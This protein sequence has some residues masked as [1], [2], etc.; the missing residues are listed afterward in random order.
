VAGKV[1]RRLQNVGKPAVVCF[2]GSTE[3]VRPREGRI[4][5]AGNLEMAALEALRL[6]GCPGINASAAEGTVE[7]LARDSSARLSAEQ[8]FVRGVFSGGSF[9]Y[10]ALA[11]LRDRLPMLHSNVSIAGVARLPDSRVSVD[12]AL[13]DLG[14]DEFTRGRVHPM[15]DPI[16]VAERMKQEA[17][18]GTVAAIIFD[19]VLGYGSHP[20]PASL[21]APVV[22]DIKR[23]AVSAGRDIVL[24]THVCGT[25]RD[26]QKRGA[27]EQQLAAAGALVLRSNFQVVRLGAAV[28]ASRPGSGMAQ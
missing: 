10:E 17:R 13:V 4:V 16:S 28:T 12:N 15:I 18:D 26:P 11:Y 6:L 5:F 8:R 20:D 7:A 21:L 1:I 9:C 19:V 2:L 3:G 25:E 23:T 27:Q 24:A 22:A 14:D